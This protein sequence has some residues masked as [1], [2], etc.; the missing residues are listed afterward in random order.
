ML[1]RPTT[2]R[3][4]GEMITSIFPVDFHA[5][6]LTVADIWLVAVA[7]VVTDGVAGVSEQAVERIRIAELVNT[8]RSRKLCLAG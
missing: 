6:P 4:V 7:V 1:A 5:T 2:T 8:D 3:D